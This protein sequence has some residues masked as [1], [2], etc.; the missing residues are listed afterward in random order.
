MLHH[1]AIND[2][3]D[4][5]MQARLVGELIL[6]E[7]QLVMCL[8]QHGAHHEGPGVIND[9]L[10]DQEVRN[11]ANAKTR[12]NINY[13][14]V[15]EGTGCFITLLCEHEQNSACKRYQDQHGEYRIAG[16]DER[17]PRAPRPACGHRHPFGFQSRT[18]TARHDSF[19]VPRSFARHHTSAPLSGSVAW[20]SEHRIFAPELTASRCISSDA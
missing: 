5:V 1:L 13:F 2:R 17:M 10:P 4:H 6:T 11:I 20:W 12:R 16:D 7:P 18:R 19:D 14:F 8:R 9:A 15:L 3:I